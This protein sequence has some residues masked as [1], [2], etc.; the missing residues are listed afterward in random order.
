[1]WRR[2][3]PALFLAILAC[4]AAAGP[5]NDFRFSILGDRTG[6]AAPGVYERVLRDVGRLDP[7][8]AITVGDT[9]EGGS[10]GTIE[11]QWSQIR[12]FLAPYRRFPIYFAAGN[13]D[14]RSAFSRQIYE[15]ETGRPATYS[16]DYQN[17]HFVILD[18]SGSFELS[19]DQ[20]A[21]LEH[22]LQRH[23]ERDPKFIFFHQ[24]FWIVPLKF[25]SSAFPLHRIA[26]E[27]GVGFVFSGHGHQ[28]MRLEREGVVYIE[29]GSSG[30]RFKGR[31]SEGFFYQHIL[32]QVKGTQARLT[33]KEL[34]APYGEGRSF[35]AADWG[36]NGLAAK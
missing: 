4:C 25:Q 23:R 7:A 9:I 30:A 6:G 20:L 22:D 24:P 35:D 26:K 29:V 15:R 32:A 33:V 5:P 18:N 28:F 21:F 36:E 34:D 2:S 31:F 8:F 13:H 14:I 1:M 11:A 27:Y 16:F 10:D 12:G 19:S 3:M 17:A